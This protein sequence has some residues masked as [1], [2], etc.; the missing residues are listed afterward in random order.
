MHY[1]LALDQG[2]SS[3]R[4]IIFDQ[5]GR[6][7][8]I[9]QRELTPLFPQPGWVEQDPTEIWSSQ[10][11]VVTEALRTARLSGTDIAAIGISNQRETTVV[12]DRQTGQP[13]WNAIVWQDRR[14]AEL[15]SRLQGDG[16][17][18]LFRHK[19][20]LAARPRAGCPPPSRRRAAGLWYGR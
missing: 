10:T 17:E 2:T 8:A 20:G 9:A 5:A 7:R 14:T 13:I 15:C 19:A 1:I 3:S 12:W 11:A 16:K 6:V 4:A 18:E